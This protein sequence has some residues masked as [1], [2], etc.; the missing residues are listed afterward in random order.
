MDT[1]EE[2]SFAFRHVFLPPKLP[3]ESEDDALAENLL[4]VCESVATTFAQ[5][6]EAS[7]QNETDKWQRKWSTVTQSIQR[8]VA[9]YSADGFDMESV[10]AQLKYMVLHGKPAS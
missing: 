8:W 9:A 7:E 10:R 6:L 3:N 1:V 5:N 4:I 2:A